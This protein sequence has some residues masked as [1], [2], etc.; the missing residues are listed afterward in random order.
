MSCDQSPNTD[1]TGPRLPKKFSNTME[2]PYGF[3]RTATCPFAFAGKTAPPTQIDSKGSL[4]LSPNLLATPTPL[5]RPKRPR[6]TPI[7]SDARSDPGMS[8]EPVAG[9]RL[10]NDP[11]ACE[12]KPLSNIDLVPTSVLPDRIRS[13]FPFQYFNAMQ[14]Q[15]FGTL[16]SSDH[17]I[18]LSAP[19]GGGKTTCFELAIARLM[20]SAHLSSVE[21]KVCLLRLPLNFEGSLHRAD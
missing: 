12:V 2:G 10:L 17:N 14:S 11:L 19:T 7:N 3:D 9:D 4:S 15:A 21:F 8:P 5:T 18:V 6:F 16:Y 1:N 13:L 20:K